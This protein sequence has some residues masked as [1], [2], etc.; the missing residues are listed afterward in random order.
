VYE[1]KKFSELRKAIA[2]RD[3]KPSLL[4][5]ELYPIL[6][7]FYR[8]GLADVKQFSGQSSYYCKIT[9]TGIV[10]W[11]ELQNPNSPLKVFIDMLFQDIDIFDN[12]SEDE[13]FDE[14]NN[15]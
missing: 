3:D 13:S 9:S 12:E 4:T 5:K 14:Q 7:I 11:N 6:K 2:V 15:S 1:Y 8:Y 10:T